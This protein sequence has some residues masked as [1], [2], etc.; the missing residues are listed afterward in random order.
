MPFQPSKDSG[1][2]QSNHNLPINLLLLSSLF[3]S[4]SAPLDASSRPS[5][6][7]RGSRV[8]MSRSELMI[9]VINEALELLD[10][11]RD[12]DS[13]WGDSDFSSDDN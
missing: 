8:S 4:E 13:C 11:G 10:E 5:T 6:S 9:S 7:P 12:L 1:S 3:P 2:N